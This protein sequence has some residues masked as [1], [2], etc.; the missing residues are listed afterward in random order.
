MPRA[1]EERASAGR[2]PRFASHVWLKT[3]KFEL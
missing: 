1:E 2:T 3:L